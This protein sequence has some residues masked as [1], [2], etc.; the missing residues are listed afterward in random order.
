MLMLQLL[1][2]SGVGGRLALVL[3][4]F[5]VRDGCNGQTELGPVSL[6]PDSVVCFCSGRL[7]NL[8]LST[9]LSVKSW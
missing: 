8:Q 2:I 4:C 7:N 1:L 6:M 5:N 9:H 3:L